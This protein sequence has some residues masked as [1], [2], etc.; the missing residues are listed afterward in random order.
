VK[1]E[2]LTEAGPVVEP[3]VEQVVKLNQGR[4]ID[5]NRGYNREKSAK[6]P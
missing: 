1:I 3:T 2:T 4:A 6:Y 5:Q